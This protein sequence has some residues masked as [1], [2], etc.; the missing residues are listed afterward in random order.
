ML[1]F[2]YNKMTL[3]HTNMNVFIIDTPKV[4]NHKHNKI[5]ENVI[6]ATINDKVP[7]V[8]YELEEWIQFKQ[9]I[10]DYLLKLHGKP[11]EKVE[12][13]HKGGRK[14]KFDFTI[15]IDSDEYSTEFKF[16][17]ERLDQTPQFV[18]LMKPSKYMSESFE[19]YYYEYY[20]PEVAELAK[21]PMPIK[22]DYLRDVH[23]NK[24]Q[25]MREYKNLYDK[26]CKGHEKFTG[27]EQDICF[28]ETIKQISKKCIKAFID[29]QTLDIQ[30]LSNSLN[31]QKDKSYMLYYKGTFILE[32]VNADDYVIVEA[33]KNPELCRFDC[34]S[35]SGKSIKVLLRWKNGNGIAFPAFQIS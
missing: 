8:Y 16:N 26:G 7:T 30:Q 19:L 9:S 4:L 27:N 22:V 18:S 32:K 21:L 31:D 17:V 12:C 20:L 2:K 3:D 23:G 35:K 13:I 11:Y 28:Y 6:G 33:I 14:H 34:K 1:S 5:R 10:K 25:C 15:R 24:P 29:K